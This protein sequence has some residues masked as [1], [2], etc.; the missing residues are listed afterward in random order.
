MDWP[1]KDYPGRLVFITG[2]CACPEYC[3]WLD[4]NDILCKG[5]KRW[6]VFVSEHDHVCGYCPKLIKAGER[7]VWMEKEIHT[8]DGKVKYKPFRVHLECLRR[9][10]VTGKIDE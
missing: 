2:N 8:P 7:Y 1:S 4:H 6:R 9:K 5:C 3:Q 10:N